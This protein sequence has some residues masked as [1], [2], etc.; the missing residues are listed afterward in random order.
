[1]GNVGAAQLPAEWRKI[2]G[3]CYPRELRERPCPVGDVDSLCSWRPSAFC[4][5]L[6]IP[7]GAAG[8]CL[9]CDHDAPGVGKTRAVPL[10]DDGWH[11][12]SPE[13]QL[14]ELE[15]LLE[16]DA[17]VPDPY[18]KNPASHLVQAWVDGLVRGVVMLVNA[19]PRKVFLDQAA[20]SLVIPADGEHPG[21]Q[22]ETE[23]QLELV[24]LRELVFTI[25]VVGGSPVP[26]MR[27]VGSTEVHFQFETQRNRFLFA[28]TLKVLRARHVDA[29]PI[30][31]RYL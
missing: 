3:D 17:P 21:S 2:T 23:T 12:K 14:E 24:S 5:A 8:G 10:A 31:I 15:G 1:M 30:Q 29:A 11:G 18:Q 4:N 13:A 20:T 7:V 19:E 22:P 28:L 9:S 26:E 6:C 16:P 25:S 27:V